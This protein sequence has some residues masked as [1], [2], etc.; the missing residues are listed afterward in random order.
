MGKMG[1]ALSGISEGSKHLAWI[2]ELESAFTHV[3]SMVGGK[4][5]I[6]G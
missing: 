2:V 4:Y 1:I 6:Y 5:Y 3:Y